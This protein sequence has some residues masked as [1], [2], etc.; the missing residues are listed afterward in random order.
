MKGFFLWRFI[1]C[2]YFMATV[3]LSLYSWS[4][5][6]FCTIASSKGG[7]FNFIMAIV[8]KIFQLV[9]YFLIFK[10]LY[11][12]RGIKNLDIVEDPNSGHFTELK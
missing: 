12:S 3:Q 5:I 11:Q 7:C 2:L 8:F 4:N 1:V 9:N 10:L 6:V